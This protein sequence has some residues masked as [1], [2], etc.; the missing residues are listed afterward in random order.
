[1]RDEFDEQTNSSLEKE[2]AE[3][4]STYR[5]QFTLL[6]QIVTVIIL[7]N[8]SII[9]FA[10]SSSKR[11]TFL[12]ILAAV[13]PMIILIVRIISGQLMLP[14]IYSTY[15]LEKK[16]KNQN[17]DWLA[18]TF[19]STTFSELLHTFELIDEK[20]SREERMEE[21]RRISKR[22][23]IHSLFDRSNLFVTSICFMASIF[24]I[25]L[26]FALK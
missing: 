13:C 9:G 26:F 21:L 5:T 10:I 15:H 16:L 18:T 24:Q 3:A 11:A 4:F 20:E 25:I 7:A 22:H 19:I 17:I 23:Y 6:T 12:F 14:I 1:M 2:I 8:I